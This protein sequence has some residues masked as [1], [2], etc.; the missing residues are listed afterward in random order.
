QQCCTQVGQGGFDGKRGSSLSHVRI[1]RHGSQRCLQETRAVHI[2][3]VVSAAENTQL[4]TLLSPM[5]IFEHVNVIGGTKQARQQGSR[6]PCE[7]AYAWLILIERIAAMF[8]QS[9]LP[10]P[11]AQHLTEVLELE[12]L[13]D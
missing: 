12:R 13:D 10:P 1:M 11:A 4:T 5:E 9:I 3:Q 8:K 7:I 2:E 6:L